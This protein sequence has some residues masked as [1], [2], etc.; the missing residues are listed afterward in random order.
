MSCLWVLRIEP[1]SARG[2]REEQDPCGAIS[3]AK[4]MLFW[5]VQ[6]LG[7][8]VIHTYIQAST[9]HTVTCQV[10]KAEGILGKQISA[11]MAYG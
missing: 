7:P 11:E 10:Q 8:S 2:G 5:T 1:G 6:A 9:L 3:P 4:L